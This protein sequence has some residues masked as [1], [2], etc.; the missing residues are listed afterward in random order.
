MKTFLLTMI[1]FLTTQIAQAWVQFEVQPLSLTPRAEVMGV[2]TGDYG[3]DAIVLTGYAAQKVAQ[4]GQFRVNTQREMI[5]V[6]GSEV[7]DLIGSTLGGAYNIGRLAIITSAAFASAGLQI[8][9]SAIYAGARFTILAITVAAT[10]GKTV[11]FAALEGLAYTVYW[12]TNAGLRIAM[13]PFSIVGTFFGYACEI[14]N[15]FG[16]RRLACE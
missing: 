7:T 1:L 13:I 8:A 12:V 2:H 5:V 16:R 3:Q 15:Y 14:P 11:V 10:I 9:F 4:E 6:T